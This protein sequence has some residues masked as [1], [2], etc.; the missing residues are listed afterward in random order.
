[1]TFVKIIRGRL[2]I[3][4]VASLALLVGCSPSPTGTSVA[5]SVI[6]ISPSG[7]AVSAGRTAPSGPGF[8]PVADVGPLV[9]LPLLPEFAS[10]AG[11][12]IWYADSDAG[13]VARLDLA[14]GKAGTAIVVDDPANSPYGSPKVI[15]ADQTGAWLADASRHSIDRIDQ[16]TNRVTHRVML[17]TGTGDHQLPIT[18]WGLEISGHTAWVTDFDRG[19]LAEVDTTSG[20]VTRTLSVGNP[21]GVTLGFGSLWVVQHRDGKIVRVDL[22]SWTVTAVITL[23]GTG[24]HS[25]CGMCVDLIVA[26]P[27]AMWVPL[28][29]GEAVVRIDPTTNK[30]TA[31]TPIG[32]EDD[33]L[34]VDAAGVWVAG[35][36]GSIPCTDTHAVLERLDPVTG[37]PTARLVIPCAFT[38][39]IVNPSGDLWLGIAD[40][41]NAVR[42]ITPHH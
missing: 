39:T 1:M 23:P 29:F 17:A 11:H 31:D 37:S 18:P 27:T 19:L 3:M 28:N 10:S 20:R 38:P 35:W 8:A 5:S 32:L 2:V 30:V 22:T 40:N 9:A 33:H 34:A 4:A 25:T 12:S 21:L 14:T 42:H 13:K 6:R 41:P 26:G 24:S 36:D 7:T 15:A 16:A